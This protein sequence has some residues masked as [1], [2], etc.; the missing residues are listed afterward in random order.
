MQICKYAN[1]GMWECG[2]VGMEEGWEQCDMQMRW[3]EPETE[4]FGRV[5]GEVGR[6]GRRGRLAHV[7][8]EQRRHGRPQLRRVVALLGVGRMASGGCRFRFA[9]AAVVERRPL[10]RRRRP[11]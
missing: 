1:M 7:S 3:N 9:P 8:V 4:L 6:R 11:R 5:R 10:G 2:N